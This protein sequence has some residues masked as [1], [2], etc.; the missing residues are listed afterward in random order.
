LRRISS[1]VP[2]DAADSI[3]SSIFLL[4]KPMGEATVSPRTGSPY[5]GTPREIVNPFALW[6]VISTPA[7]R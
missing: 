6:A 7:L 3:T 1:R 2:T 4:I 5:N